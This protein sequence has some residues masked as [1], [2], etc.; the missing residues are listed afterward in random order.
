MTG[1]TSGRDCP[2]LAKTRLERGTQMVYFRAINEFSGHL[3][4][5]G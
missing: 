4:N 2:A 5:R 3:P 1:D